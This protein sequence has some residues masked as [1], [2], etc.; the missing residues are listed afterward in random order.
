MEERL[1][2]DAGR[3]KF[4]EDEVKGS[5]PA[6]AEVELSNHPD[7]KASTP[8]LV[9]EFTL[10]VPGWMAGAGR[11]ALLPVG[12][13]SAPEKH[14]FDHTERV[15]PIYFTFPFARTD[16]VNI[17]LPL[18]WQIAT[19]PAPAKQDAHILTYTMQAE[20]K[21]GTLHLN[22]KLNVDVLMLETKYYA[23]L[24]NFFQTV[25]TVDEQQV[26]LQPTAASASN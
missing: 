5:I 16:D 4:L 24:R 8:P 15:Q 25:R 10:K 23:A 19:L 26:I 13:F 11:R 18:G 9:A 17:E 3:K 1:S 14:L 12:L 6:A 7:W 21:K 22:R 20:N 2:D